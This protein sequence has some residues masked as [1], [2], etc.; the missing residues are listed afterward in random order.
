MIDTRSN[1]WRY[2][3]TPA[4]KTACRA[5]AF[6]LYRNTMNHCFRLQSRHVYEISNLPLFGKPA[7]QSRVITQVMDLKWKFWLVWTSAKAQFTSETY[8]CKVTRPDRV[9]LSLVGRCE[10]GRR[11]NTTA[12]HGCRSIVSHFWTFLPTGQFTVQLKWV[13]MSRVE[14]GGMKYAIFSRD[15]AFQL[16][17][18]PNHSNLQQFQS[19]LL[20]EWDTIKSHAVDI[21]VTVQYS[22]HNWYIHKYGQLFGTLLIRPF[23]KSFSRIQCFD[24]MVVIRSKIT[25][26]IR[27]PMKSFVQQW[28]FNVTSG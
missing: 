25:S 1:V 22:I 8:N 13:G 11:L 23:L 16:W 12:H 6:R 3:F 14:L 9:L 21:T 10:I 7:M 26:W 18:T 2:W 27:H 4:L 24:K 20:F 28:H 5:I 15:E 19:I 17:R